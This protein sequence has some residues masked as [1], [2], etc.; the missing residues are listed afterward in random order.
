M[1]KY[2]DKS[3]QFQIMLYLPSSPGANKGCFFYPF[4]AMPMKVASSETDDKAVQL[5]RIHIDDLLADIDEK[6]LKKLA[7]N[8]LMNVEFVKLA[9]RFELSKEDIKKGWTKEKLIAITD[10]DRKHKVRH[11]IINSLDKEQVF[12][13]LNE[14]QLRNVLANDRC[15]D[16]P[17]EDKAA[18][19]NKGKL[20]QSLNDADRWSFC[21][22]VFKSEV[23]A[24]I[25]SNASMCRTKATLWEEHIRNSISSL[26]E[27]YQEWQDKSGNQ[28]GG[29]FHEDTLSIGTGL[30]ESVVR[31]IGNRITVRDDELLSGDFNLW[32]NV[33]T[34]NEI[35]VYQSVGDGVVGKYP[36]NYLPIRIPN[37]ER[38]ELSLF[39]RKNVPYLMMG[40]LEISC[41]IGGGDNPA[42]VLPL[43]AK[44]QLLGSLVVVKHEEC[45]EFDTPELVTLEY[46]SKW[47]ADEIQEAKDSFVFRRLKP[48]G[49]E[50][51]L[52]IRS[53]NYIMKEF[54]TA[55]AVVTNVTKVTVSWPDDKPGGQR[56]VPDLIKRNNKWIFCIPKKVW[57]RE[58]TGS[59]IENLSD[60]ELELAF[61]E[62]DDIV[63][64]YRR[65][66]Q[67]LYRTVLHIL[68]LKASGQVHASDVDPIYSRIGN[69]LDTEVM[70]TQEEFVREFNDFTENSVPVP[71]V[72]GEIA[73]AFP[74]YHFKEY[75]LNQNCVD[76]RYKS[77]IA[78]DKNDTEKT[79]VIDDC[80][81]CWWKK[82][83]SS[84]VDPKIKLAKIRSLLY[85][86]GTV[87]QLQSHVVPDKILELVDG[88]L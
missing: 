51:A 48:I 53:M 36:F 8:E 64:N 52:D 26:F 24:R 57:E 12:S 66:I 27:K 59:P 81:R 84:K 34:T 71:G 33:L 70:E 76:C 7:A 80:M 45:G 78:F 86:I 14:E 21:R 54:I 75:T 19:N 85:C 17:E 65:E 79:K 63:E 18:G 73:T 1:G 22:S 3:L 41:G 87:K 60:C 30:F 10:E 5:L 38:K 83:E 58:R 42:V 49:S 67:S 88:I 82:A 23:Y 40:L 11:P 35:S 69:Y 16:V 29:S 77:I 61:T 20:V 25:E 62:S 6:Q 50:G 9:E 74:R 56:E 2:N 32:D 72:V 43:T 39:D 31:V 37:Q 44:G 55:I 46:I 15:K 28:G 47:I 13:L 68:G 4:F